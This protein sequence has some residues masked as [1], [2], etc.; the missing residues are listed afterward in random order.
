MWN[1]HDVQINTLIV[2]CIYT[3]IVEAYLHLQLEVIPYV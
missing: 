3:S 1:M 2:L